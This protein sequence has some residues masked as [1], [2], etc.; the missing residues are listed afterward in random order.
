MCVCVGGGCIGEGCCEF[1]VLIYT[2]IFNVA[3]YIK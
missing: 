1:R 3:R 2:S